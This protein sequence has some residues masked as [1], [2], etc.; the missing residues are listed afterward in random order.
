MRRPRRP[1]RRGGE[2]ATNE[3]YDQRYGVCLKVFVDSLPRTDLSTASRLNIASRMRAICFSFRSISLSLEF[4][5]EESSL[6]PLDIC[7]VCIA[8]L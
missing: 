7:S 1:P 3:R 6:R 4:A 8:H 5:S 2:D